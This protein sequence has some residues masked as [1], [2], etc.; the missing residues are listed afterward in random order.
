L[1]SQLRDAVLSQSDTTLTIPE[2]DANREWFAQQHVALVA[3][4]N[5][6]WQTGDTPNEKLLKLARTTA[7]NREQTRI[8]LSNIS[9]KRSRRYSRILNLT[10]HRHAY[11]L[12]III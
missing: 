5:D 1:P 11:K 6:P 3:S 10:Q 2:S 8:K 4:G 9:L 7:Q 12:L